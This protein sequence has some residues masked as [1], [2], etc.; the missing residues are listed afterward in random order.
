MQYLLDTNHASAVFSY[1]LDLATDPRATSVD[2]FGLPLPAIGELWFMVFASARLQKNQH[3]LLEIMADFTRWPFDENAAI[4]FGRI[5]VEL[6][7]IGRPIPNV[8]VQIAAIA[9]ANGLTLLTA[10]SHFGGITGL[11][12]QNWL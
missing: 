3:R 6:K 9:R 5:K 10:D 11:N 2:Q 1:K 8:D 4:E 12:L 7:K